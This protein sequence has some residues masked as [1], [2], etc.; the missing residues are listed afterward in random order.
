VAIAHRTAYCASKSGLLGFTRALALELVSERI[1]VNGISPGPFATELNAP[2]LQNPEANA[3]FISKIPLG[4]WGRVEEVGQLALFLARRRPALLPDRHPDRRRL[5]GAVTMSKFTAELIG[6]AL[7]VLLGDGV[8]ANVVLNK[9]KGQNSGWIVIATGW[10]LAV[11][12]AVYCV[13]QISGAHLNPAVTLGLAV[14]GQF[15]WRDVPGYIAAQMAGAFLGAVIV[16]LAYLPHWL[17]TSDAGPSGRCSAPGP[18]FAA[19]GEFTDRNASALLC[20]CWGC[21]RSSRRRISGRSTAS[22]ADLAR[23]SSACWC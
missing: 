17:E 14:I 20:W 16:W 15:A 13:G 23:C 2:I 5:D 3:Q 21:W 9:S 1:T 22:T 19:R 11:A 18:P 6:T 4:R 8:V 10:G 7:L 12:L